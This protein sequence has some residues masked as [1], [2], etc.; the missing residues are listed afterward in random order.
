MIISMFGL[1]RAKVAARLMEK[2]AIRGS[3]PVAAFATPKAG[4]RC[5]VLRDHQ[6]DHK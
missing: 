2:S 3:D 4:T 6:Q 1:G 5:G